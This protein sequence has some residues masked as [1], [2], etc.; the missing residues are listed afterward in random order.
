EAALWVHT[1][2]GLAR[3]T[4]EAI[5]SKCALVDD[6][7][8]AL[9]DRVLGDPRGALAGYGLSLIGDEPAQMVG[10][11]RFFWAPL[12]LMT[13]LATPKG[14]HPDQFSI[15]GPGGPGVDSGAAGAAA[16]DPNLKFED[17][18]PK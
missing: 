18:N 2:L 3:A 16:T 17:L 11:D 1:D 15:E 8:I 10:F 9:V 4:R 14:M 13:I 7:P 6:D 12:G 5:G